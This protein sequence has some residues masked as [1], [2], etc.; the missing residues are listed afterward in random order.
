MSHHHFVP[1]KTPRPRA[2]SRDPS[3]EY[4]QHEREYEQPKV[5]E[6]APDIPVKKRPDV[7]VASASSEEDEV[8]HP[9]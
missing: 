2:S 8:S 7:T 3:P 6:T 5:E 4:A 1:K 9:S